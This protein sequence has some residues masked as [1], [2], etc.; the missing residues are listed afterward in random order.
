VIGIDL[1]IASSG[2]NPLKAMRLTHHEYA[3]FYN[4]LCD[5]ICREDLHIPDE[6]P[7][8]HTSSEARR[9]ALNICKRLA[10]AGYLEYR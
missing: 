1:P 9:K 2:R 6:D 5:V 7:F 10:L 8:R 3:E 4:E